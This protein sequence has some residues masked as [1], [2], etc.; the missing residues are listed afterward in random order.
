MRR[1]QLLRRKLWSTRHFPGMVDGCDHPLGKRY[2]RSTSV[3]SCE[4]QGDACT[5]TFSCSP[6]CYVQFSIFP[7]SPFPSFAAGL[8]GYGDYLCP[9][10]SQPWT[11]DQSAVHK[12]HPSCSQSLNAVT[13]YH[14][15][16]QPGRRCFPLL[17][18][19]TFWTLADPSL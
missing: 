15:A 18:L 16:R 19:R 4:T 10:R 3:W 14:H 8:G 17:D 13:C 6:S 9:P 1:N 7:G 2:H 12:T 11:V 5:W